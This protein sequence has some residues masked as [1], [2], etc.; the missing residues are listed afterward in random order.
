MTKQLLL[1]LAFSI[2]LSSCEEFVIPK[3][4]IP[5]GYPTTYLKLSSDILSQ[6]QGSYALRNT[7]LVSSLNE[8]GFPGY[9][10][11]S[12]VSPPFSDQI[13][14]DEAIAKAKLFCSQNPVETGVNSPDD[15]KLDASS[16]TT[17]YNGTTSWSLVFARQEY[18]TYE[19]SDTRI[20]FRITNG[21][22][23][24]CIGNWYPEIYIPQDFNISQDEAK[25]NLIN[26][27]VSHYTLAGVKYYF[28]VT[29]E[30]LNESVVSLS[31]YPV[32]TD[33]KIELRVAWKIWIQS[34][35]YIF[36][37]DVMTGDVIGQEATAIS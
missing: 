25:K 28:P 3:H 5:E 26:R 31:I 37:V 35:S 1:V 24:S 20:F 36:Y 8:F 32:T 10:D 15:L 17:Y 33:D 7:Y 22:V 11:V 29:S 23:V 21:E 18:D 16:S 14:K 6:K 34:L 13:T 9:G 27:I 2:L 30:H 4:E 19:V 12:S